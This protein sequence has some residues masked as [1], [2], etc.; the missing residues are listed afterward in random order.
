MK[1]SAFHAWLSGVVPPELPAQVIAFNFNIAQTAVGFEV[2]LIGA[3]KYDPDNSDWACEET[4]T[5]RPKVFAV[6]YAESGKE[7]Q[8]FLEWASRAVR[9]FVEG[10]AP[11][12]STVRKAQAVTVGFVDGE[13][14]LVRK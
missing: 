13:L 1:V 5:S 2:E 3:S 9:E 6:S 11:N 12:A 4:W 10:T 7:W 14:L 8:P